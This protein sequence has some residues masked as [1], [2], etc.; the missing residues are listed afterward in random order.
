MKNDPYDD[1][2]ECYFDGISLSENPY[3]YQSENYL[4]WEAGWIS[5]LGY[6]EYEE[7][8]YRGI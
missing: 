7:Q 4:Q 1:G 2:Y 8:Q 5:G 3:S 6:S